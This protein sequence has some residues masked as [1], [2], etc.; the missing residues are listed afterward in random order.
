MISEERILA[1]NEPMKDEFIVC[2]PDSELIEFARAIER[3]ANKQG[4]EAM[5]EKI[6]YVKSYDDSLYDFTQKI[7]YL[8]IE[9]PK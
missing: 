2:A 1:L 4:Q 9:E 5:R 8:E 7:I 6:L 3:E